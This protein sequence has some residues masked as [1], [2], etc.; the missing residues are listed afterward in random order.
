MRVESSHSGK[1]GLFNGSWKNG[2]LQEEKNKTLSLPYT[3][4]KNKSQLD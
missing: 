2:L 3:I 1:E 4:Y